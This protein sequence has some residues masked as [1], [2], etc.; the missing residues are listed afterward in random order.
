MGGFLS[1]DG[2]IEAGPQITT[3]RWRESA[4]G[5]TA[6]GVGGLGLDALPLLE[7]GLYFLAFF[8]ARLGVHRR[9]SWVGVFPGNYTRGW[10]E[11]LTHMAAFTAA[12]ARVE[13]RAEVARVKVHRHYGMGPGSCGEVER[14]L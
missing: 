13:L 12:K 6:A 9:D 3:H 14:G 8:V 10:S 7:G 5:V 4:Y 11:G 1:A 2:L